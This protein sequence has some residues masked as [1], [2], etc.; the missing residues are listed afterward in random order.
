MSGHREILNYVNLDLDNITTPL[1]VTQLQQ[2]LEL[3]GYPREKTEFLVDGF[4]EGFDLG[5]RGDHRVQIKSPNLK[6]VIGDEVELWNKVMKEVKEKRYAGPYEEI[7]FKNFIQSPIGLVPKDGGTKTR[8]IFHLSYP[9]NG[10]TSVNANT[11]E[12]LT[13]VN[14]QDFD[15]AVRLCLKAGPNCAAAKSDFTSAFRHLPLARTWWK[16]LVMKAKHPV[17]QIWYYFVDKCLPFGAARSCALFQAFSD[18]MSFIM[19]VKTGRDNVNY[20]DDFLFVASLKLW[21]DQQVQLFIN[22][23]KKINFPLSKEKTYWGTTQLTFL[24][25]TLDTVN[26]VIIIPIE[27]IEKA[28]DLLHKALSKKNNKITLRDLQ[29]LAGY[30]NFLCKAVVPGR[31]FTRRLYADKISHLKPHHHLYLKKEMKDDMLTWLTFL[32]T[33]RI[34]NR[35]FFELDHDL[36]YLETGIATD[37]SRNSQLGVGGVWDREW[38]IMQWDETFID[39][40]EPSINYLELYG[41][42]VAV[43]LW[44]KHFRNQKIWIS[45]DNMSVV[46]MLNNNSSNCKQCMV[47]IRIIVIHSMVFNVRIM[48]KHVKGILNTVPD[49]LSRLKYKQFKKL[50]REKNLKF[51]KAPEEV[52]ADLIPMSKLWITN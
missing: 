17:T 14:Y 12:E 10:V 18:A 1:R 25:L 26:Q 36:T 7:P 48:A 15:D 42:T 46:H 45:C 37:A 31:A 44:A 5:Y 9:K 34:F 28:R 27:K 6:F 50:C 49:M 11:P 52:P 33:P 8:L 41:V 24:G 30:L 2:E 38:F 35:P 21:C 23:C 22:L 47:L 29:K 32:E 19:K 3:A 4:T 51:N 40:F 43:L 16:F 20:L 13:S 39:N